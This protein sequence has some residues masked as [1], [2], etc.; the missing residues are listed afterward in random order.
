MADYEKT[1]AKAM[2]ADS[3]AQIFYDYATLKLGVS[4][5]NI[6]ELVNE[7]ADE[8]EILLAVK[9]WIARST[10]QGESDVYIFF[11]GHGLASSDGEDMYLLPFDGSPRLLEKTAILREELFKDIASASPSFCN[12]LP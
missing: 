5:T 2:Y 4:P 12:C 1:P 10:K 7:K 11:A 8:S 3:D 6:M 9:D